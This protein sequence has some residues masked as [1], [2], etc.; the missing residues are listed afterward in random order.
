MSTI[1]WMLESMRRAPR[2]ERR[3]ALRF[4]MW[5]TTKSAMCVHEDQR[6]RGDN[7][8]TQRSLTFCINLIKTY[9]L[10]PLHWL[11]YPAKGWFTQWTFL[12][13]TVLTYK[14][15]GIHIECSTSWKYTK[16]RI[17]IWLYI[18]N[19]TKGLLQ[20]MRFFV[21]GILVW[22]GS[23]CWWLQQSWKWSS[24]L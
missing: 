13:S 18:E 19:I 16:P 17:T 14:W 10:K 20:Q 8:R 6:R 4:R 15:M 11:L 7:S 9:P 23:G 2:R 24:L 3:G 21:K 1:A 5:H 12:D 22:F